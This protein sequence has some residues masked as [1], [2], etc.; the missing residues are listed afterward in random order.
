M[1]AAIM[2]LMSQ[3][4]NLVSVG[5]I[6]LVDDSGE[7]QLVQVNINRGGPDE[8]E[9]VIDDVPR[10]AHYGFAYCPPDGSEVVV[11]HIG[12]N[13]TAGI[14][15]AT[16][17]REARPRDLQPGEAMLFNSLTD[18]FVR[19]SADGKIHSKGDWEHEGYLKAT[20]DVL[21]HSG[22]NAATMKVHR[23]KYNA[24]H[25]TGVQVGAASSGTT[26]QPTP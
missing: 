13:R 24:H 17:Y 2:R 9:E 19:M 20:G 22:T 12:G 6:R 18:T 3:V 11:L 14:A 26:D 10:M 7:Q 21:D 16:G 5:H 25:H 1:R 23:D 4:R 8:L 15:I